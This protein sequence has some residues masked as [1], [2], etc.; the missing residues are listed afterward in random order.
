MKCSRR[1]NLNRKCVWNFWIIYIE[2]GILCGCAI[3]MLVVSWTNSYMIFECV[4]V[5]NYHN[6]NDFSP[7]S[8]FFI[9]LQVWKLCGLAGCW[10]QSVCELRLWCSVRF[11]SWSSSIARWGSISL[12]IVAHRQYRRVSIKV[13]CCLSVSCCDTWLRDSNRTA[14]LV[15]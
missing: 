12:G 15:V 1:N 9:K 6:C 8:I 13:S 4:A 10:L 11:C 3:R 2:C 7:V 14:I 5:F